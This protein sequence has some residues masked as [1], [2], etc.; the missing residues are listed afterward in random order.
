MRWWVVALLASGCVE[1]ELST[2][3][4]PVGEGDDTDPAVIDIPDTDPPEDTAVA[5]D[6]SVNTDDT[7]VPNTTVDSDL[8][9]VDTGTLIVVAT[10]PVYAHTSTTLFEVDPLT[11]A[12]ATVGD[13]HTSSGPEVNFI[14]LAIDL[15]GHM[16]G[17]NYDF[18]Y[19]IDPTTA[20]VTPL[21][22]VTVNMYALAFT[23]DGRLFA[24]YG[25]NIVNVDSVTCV[26]TQLVTDTLY[27][28]SGDLVGLPDGYLYWT[29]RGDGTDDL[30]RVDPTWGYTTWVGEVGLEG[31]YGLGY[32]N[33]ELY[34][35]SSEGEIARIN[36]FTGDSVVVNTS[37]NRS[38]WGAATNPVLWAP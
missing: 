27:E 1:Y 8:P 38:W 36:P 13:F 24:G 3:K 5:I 18:L 10:A 11:G 35:F 17:A 12:Q 20:E 26:T 33:G 22:P 14:D 9:V 23:S 6:T 29:V 32:D 21:C 31:L 7:A 30:I 34:G 16:V 15:N 25:D 28:T 37:A 4:D 19:Q 2:A